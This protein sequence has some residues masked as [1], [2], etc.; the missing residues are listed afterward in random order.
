MTDSI[1]DLKLQLKRALLHHGRLL[2]SMKGGANLA[3]YFDKD[4]SQAAR[5]ANALAARL[6]ELDK[7]FPTKSWTDLPTG[8]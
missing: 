3:A 2:E 6:A 7:D 4:V 5:D 1:G 8:T